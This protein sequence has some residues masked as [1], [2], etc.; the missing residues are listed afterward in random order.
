MTE[1]MFD[2]AWE[3]ERARIGA[4][5]E[6]FDP[7]TTHILESIGVDEGWKCLEIG[8][9]GGTIASW[10]CERVGSSG[11]VVAIDLD[12]RFI[13]HLDHPNLEVRQHDIASGPIDDRKFDLIHARLVLEHVPTRSEVVTQLTEMLE[14][15]GWLVL[16]D[17]D[18]TEQPFVP[19]DK[20]FEYP[21]THAGPG[22][23]SKAIADVLRPLGIVDLD[24]GRQLPA[25]LAKNG[26][27]DVDA[28]YQSH[29]VTGGSARANYT[30]LMMEFLREQIIASKGVT[31]DEYQHI[32]DCHH[33]PEHLWMSPGL[34]SAW[35]RKPS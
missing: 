10:L 19:A 24:Y 3:Q 34:C 4:G 35:G 32:W 9:G 33:D 15:G 30:L 13:E 14:P 26:L 29:L 1:Y 2:P 20:Y 18:F 16:E 23:I 17:I 22:L 8:A 31:D 27:E 5:E 7:A 12:I 21:K 6:L 11:H 28:R 25:E